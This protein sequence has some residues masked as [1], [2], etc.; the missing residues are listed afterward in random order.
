MKLSGFRP[1]PLLIALYALFLL[2]AILTIPLRVSEVLQLLG[3]WDFSWPRLIGW[4]AQTPASAPLHYFVQLPFILLGGHSRL[5]A[6]LPSLLFALGAC[7][8][9]LRLVERVPLA[10]PYLPLLVFMLI[11]VHYQLATQARPFEQALFLLLL[12]T[13]CYLR[14]IQAP[15]FRSAAIYAGV[16]VLCLYTDPSSYLPAIGYLL[17]L[18]RF[19]HTAQ[20]RR[21][22]WFAL[23]ATI[24]P[25]VLFLPYYFWT[26]P[27]AN[28]D[29]L[30]ER[31]AF[32]TDSS[33]FVQVLHSVAGGGWNG[34]IAALLLLAGA[35]AGVRASFHPPTTA[36]LRRITLFCLFGGVVTTIVIPLLVDTWNGYSFLPSHALWAVPGMIILFFN[37][38]E[39]LPKKEMI[40]PLTTAVAVLSILL[41]ALGDVEY[42]GNRSEDM[43]AVAS[44]VGPELTGDSCVVFVSERLSKSL[45]LLFDPELAKHE[46]R[47]FFHRRVILAS[48]PYVR[49][50]QQQDAESFFRG[51][52]FAEAK[53]V[54]AGG[55]QIIVMEEP[56]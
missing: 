55:G 19:V 44:L 6:R 30:F 34:F 53:R 32:S 41:F 46:C 20:E 9:F 28:P 54:R 22:I 50:D 15:T 12:A 10:R 39:W 25:V 17:F 26:Y 21:V 38:L 18:V 8:L 56:N 1:G 43:Q 24:I 13:I 7:Y 52:N 14:L 49:P 47:D 42:F 31:T 45:F 37:A 27:Q 3:S 36:R 2:A 35:L 4:V 29:W 48:H 11:P 51:L 16:L 5:P 33:I 23:P 40:Q